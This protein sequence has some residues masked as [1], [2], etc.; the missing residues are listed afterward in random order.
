[1]AII[2]LP[3]RRKQTRKTDAGEIANVNNKETYMN[4]AIC[5]Q[6]EAVQKGPLLIC[7]LQGHALGRLGAL[8]TETLSRRGDSRNG[9]ELCLERIDAPR[10]GD[11][12]FRRGILGNDVHG[13]V[14]H[15]C[16]LFFFFFADLAP[17]FVL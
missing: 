8:E 2:L 5:S 6:W 15:G 7:R 10:R 12:T 1:M 11:A 16:S 17:V 13:Y 9:L 4:L 3:L 14:G